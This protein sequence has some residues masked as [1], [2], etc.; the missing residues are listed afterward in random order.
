MDKKLSDSEQYV[1][2]FIQENIQTIPN[3][4]IIK[5]SELPMFQP[6][7]SSVQ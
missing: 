7:R 5:L 1:W 3:Y 6:Q 2:G 4:S